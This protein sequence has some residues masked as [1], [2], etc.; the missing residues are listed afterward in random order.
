MKYVAVHF[1]KFENPTAAY[2]MGLIQATTITMVEGINLWNLSN[3]TSGSTKDL[4]F[5]F[6]ALGIIAEFDDY[7]S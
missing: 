3:I 1:D 2:A 7:F 5:D 4:M 6:I